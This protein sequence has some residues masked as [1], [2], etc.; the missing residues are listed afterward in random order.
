MEKSIATHPK[1]I[2][3][4]RIQTSESPL[5]QYLFLR[6]HGDNLFVWHDIE[7]ELNISGSS[8]SESLKMGRK[9]WRLNSFRTV[10]CGFRYTLPERDEHGCNAL[11]CQMM[12]SYRSYNGIYFD[13]DLGHNCFVSFASQEALSLMKKLQ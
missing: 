3:I 11:F 12:E 5:P 1:L 4:A 8:I 10:N 6:K 7:R 2:H 9:A 13:E